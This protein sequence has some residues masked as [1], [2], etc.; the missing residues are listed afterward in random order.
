MKK[1]PEK[2]VYITCRKCKNTIHGKI[3]FSNERAVFEFLDDD[4]YKG[5]PKKSASS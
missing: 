2:E 3:V 4:T 5:E 1:M